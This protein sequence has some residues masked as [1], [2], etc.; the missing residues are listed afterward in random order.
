MNDALKIDK[1]DNVAVVIRPIAKGD[2]VIYNN[3][4]YGQGKLEALTDIPIY[5]KIALNE[6]EE[7]EKVV[8]YGEHIGEA[9][10]KIQAGEHVHTH[11]VSSVRENLR[12]CE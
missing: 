2:Q 10:R 1:K 4:E 8:K 11:N 6:I 12:N 7:G 3:Y 5:H 9:S